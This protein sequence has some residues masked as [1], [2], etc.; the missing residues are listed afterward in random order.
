[1][2]RVFASL[3]G[4]VA[5]YVLAAFAGYWAI[6]L[7]SSNSFDRAVEASMTAL[8]AVG[9]AGA[10]VGLIAGLVLSRTKRA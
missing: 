4:L 7:L 3:F 6:E 1:M 9:P 8:F 5:G 10:V 2:A